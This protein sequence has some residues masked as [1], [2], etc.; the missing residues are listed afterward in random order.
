MFSMVLASLGMF[1]VGYAA[2]MMI[3]GLPQ[4]CSS[5]RCVPFAAF[6][7]FLAI[8]LWNPEYWVAT[9]IG[10]ITG[11]TILVLNG[12]RKDCTDVCNNR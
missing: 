2:V 5:D 11:M 3:V 4:V 7:T 6:C 10:V 8:L 12:M 9:G 1:I